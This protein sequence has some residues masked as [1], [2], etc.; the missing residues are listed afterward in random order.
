MK[1]PVR[2]VAVIKLAVIFALAIGIIVL[3]ARFV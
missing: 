1:D 3:L 2:R